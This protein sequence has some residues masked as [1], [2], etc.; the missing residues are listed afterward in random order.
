MAGRESSPARPSETKPQSS[1]SSASGNSSSDEAPET[2]TSPKKTKA[3]RSFIGEAFRR[4]LSSSK[5]SKA[6]ESKLEHLP[7]VGFVGT[8]PK[9]L[10]RLH[11]KFIEA[12]Y[13]FG[14]KKDQ[15]FPESLVVSTLKDTANQVSQISIDAKICDVFGC[16]IIVVNDEL[17]ETSDL[18]RILQNQQKYGFQKIIY[19]H[20]KERTEAFSRRIM[21]EALHKI[22]GKRRLD[23]QLKNDEP[24]KEELPKRVLDAIGQETHG[25]CE[26]FKNMI[27]EDNIDLSQVIFVLGGAGPDASSSFCKTLA[28][29]DYIAY[30]QAA[31]PSKINYEKKEGP[32]YVK[33]YEMAC[34]IASAM[35]MKTMVVPCNTAH[36]RLDD[37]REG[38]EVVDFREATIRQLSEAG[39]QKVILLGTNRTTGV[40]IE[41]GKPGGI[42]KEF[43][44][45]NKTQLGL[46]KLEFIVPNEDQQERIMQAINLVK[47]GM[48]DDAKEIILDVISQMR[49]V[50]G[51]VPVVLACTE[52]PIALPTD[53]LSAAEFLRF[54]PG[55]FVVDAITKQK[56]SKIAAAQS[57]LTDSGKSEAA[58]APKTQTTSRPDSPKSETLQG[59][60]NQ[61]HTQ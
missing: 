24:I 25:K 16:D 10:A 38:L 7:T 45:K 8:D 6:N 22:S 36:A 47:E 30:H 1:G 23:L 32:S 34:K 41:G 19:R 31:A 28:G 20:K 46:K 11:K 15:E 26:T 27:E 42:Y 48:K 61:Q 51:N 21:D 50:S 35:G 54:N 49:G 13:Y 14:L 59:Q 9:K 18:L 60:Q 33:H 2:K 40:G 29:K 37:F 58:P 3:R 5:K 4:L 44:D 53:G 17:D 43:Y 39:H 57:G 55:D 52:L 56:T 12:G